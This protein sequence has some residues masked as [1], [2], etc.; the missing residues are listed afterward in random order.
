MTEIKVLLM[1]FMDGELAPDEM[2][3]VN[4]AL[5]RDAS[6]RNEY[7]SLCR[8]CGKL[9]RLSFDLPDEEEMKR[10]WKSPFSR[11]A[12]LFAWSLIV[13]GLLVLSA[14]TLYA[15]LFLSGEAPLVT[16]SLVAVGVGFLVL[17]SLK[18]RDR[19]STY[20]KD[21]YKDIEK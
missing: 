18:V 13:A 6:L 17:F 5:M 12:S 8:A 19:V 10:L 20:S 14:Y 16:V 2:A 7:E 9:D 1:G 4:D 11:S 15:I 21:P 3:R